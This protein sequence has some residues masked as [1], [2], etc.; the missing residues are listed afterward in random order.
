MAKVILGG[1]MV[2][3][4]A[5]FEKVLIDFSE[6]KV[7]LINL[8]QKTNTSSI[9]AVRLMYPAIRQS[10]V[11]FW[12]VIHKPNRR[13]YVK[14]VSSSSKYSDVFLRSSTTLLISLI[15]LWLLSAWKEM[16]FFQKF[17]RSLPGKGIL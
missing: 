1:N 14:S 5:V 3:C 13:I 16:K 11:G 9:L 12:S 8:Y 10:T 4:Q 2:I 17:L 15:R 6:K 7:T